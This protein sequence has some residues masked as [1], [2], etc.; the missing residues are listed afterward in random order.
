MQTPIGQKIL[1]ISLEESGFNFLNA[2]LE[3]ISNCTNGSY[4]FLGI[5]K[6]IESETVLGILANEGK[7]LDE[8]FEYCMSE[9]PCRLVYDNQILN[10]PCDVQKDFLR[11]KS[12]GLESFFG[13]PLLHPRKGVVAHF[14]SYSATPDHFSQISMDCMKL[15]QSL[16]AREIVALIDKYSLQEIESKV[17]L[18]RQ[19]ALTDTLTSSMNRRAL[20]SDWMSFWQIGHRFGSLAILDIDHFKKINDV[21]GHDIG[22]LCLQRFS[23]TFMENTDEEVIKFYR[24]GGEEFCILAPDL[25]AQGLEKYIANIKFKLIQSLEGQSE[26]PNFTFSGGVSEYSSNDLACWLRNADAS[27]YQAKQA[28]RDR[29]S[30]AAKT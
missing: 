19:A 22:D 9:Q 16:V 28:G 10:I 20:E 26:L 1:Q 21:Y 4:C 30:I 2:V 27:L 8:P 29:V 5:L 15:I 13:S 6:D 3:E 7:I 12:S 14:A 24:L 11:K 17:T 25:Q 18:W 23:K